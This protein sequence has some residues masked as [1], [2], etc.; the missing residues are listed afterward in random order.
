MEEKEIEITESE[1][2]NW[3]NIAKYKAAELENHI[4]RSRDQIQ[5]AYYDGVAKAL[6]KILPLSDALCEA[7]KTVANESDRRGIEMLLRKF[8]TTLA[9]MG[10]EQIEVRVGDK[11]DPYIHSSIGSSTT[12]ENKITA[13]YQKGYRMNGKVI[14]PAMVGL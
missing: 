14:R 5:L 10:M 7:I 13:V 8:D 2:P 11:F 4:K 9:E 6:T 12:E 1:T 3:E